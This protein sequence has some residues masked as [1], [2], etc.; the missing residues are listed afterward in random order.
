MNTH[1]LCGRPPA[2][3]AALLVAVLATSATGAASAQVPARKPVKWVV[4]CPAPRAA[5]KPESAPAAALAVPDPVQ[6]MVDAL[7]PSPAVAAPTLVPTAEAGLAGQAA[8]PEGRLAAMDQPSQ[9]RAAAPLP[10]AAASPVAV[11]RVATV[12]RW[13]VLTSDMTLSKTLARWAQEAGY[14]LQWDAPRNFLIGAPTGFSGDFETAV[15][16]LLSTPG[17]R[18]SEYPLEACV[19]SN[20][21]PLLRITRYGEQARECA[22]ASPSATRTA[23]AP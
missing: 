11:F 21:P 16:A 7:G 2:A 8:A 22:V 15:S 12:P 9:G 4:T 19:Y 1:E 10:A 3:M 18:L 5:A 14:R 20:S 6:G 17:I 23:N 13:E